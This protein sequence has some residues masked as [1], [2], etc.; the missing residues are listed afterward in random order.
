MVADN[1]GVAVGVAEEV[2][3]HAAPRTPAAWPYQVGVIPS[4]GGSFQHRAEADQLRVALDGGGTTVLSQVLT[5]TGGVGKTQLAADYARTAW[6]ESGV[7]VLVW[8]SASDTTAVISGYAQAGVEIQGA[9]PADPHSAAKAFLAWLQPK[10]QGPRCRWLVV[11]DDVT[12]PSDL[13]DWWPPASPTGRTVVTTRRKDAALA[14]DERRMIE[15]GV[16]TATESL[17][18]LTSALAVHDRREPDAQLAALAADLGHLPLALSQAAAYLVDVGVDCTAYRAL[19]SDRA[20]TLADAAPDVL[21]DGQAQTVAAAWGLSIDRAD[22]LRPVGLARPTLQLCAFLDSNGIPAAVV[23]SRSA[24]A[25]LTSYHSKAPDAHPVSADQARLAVRALYRLS[26]INHDPG[27]LHRELHVHQL[28]QHSVRDTLTSTQHDLLARTAADALTESWPEV[29]RDVDL[30]QVL[31]ANTVALTRYSGEAL[32]R[33]DLHRVLFRTGHSLGDAGQ[34]TAARDYFHH[35]SEIATAIL[36]AAH[37]DTL[38][39]R[40]GFARWQGEAGDAASAVDTL[41]E[42]LEDRLGLLGQDHPETLHT[43]HELARLR[44]EA[45]DA[46]GAVDALTPLVEHYLRV[47]GPDHLDT[48]TARHELARWQG[49]A[50][51]AVG[52]VDALTPLV[53]HYLRVLGPDH[54]DTLTARSNLARLRGEAGDVVGAVNAF[55]ELLEDRLRVLGPDHPRTLRARHELANWRIYAGDVAGAVNGFAAL[56][57]DA[58]RLLGPEHPDTLTARLNLAVCLGKAGDATGAVDALITLLGDYLR[59]IGPDHPEPLTARH[60]LARLRGEAG[61][62]AGAVT[63]FTELLQDRLRVQGPDHPHTLRAR[64]ELARWR[65][66]AGDVAGAV[67]AFTELL[68]DRL[69][70]HG[71]DHPDILSTRRELARWQA[72]ERDS[73]VTIVREVLPAEPHSPA[74]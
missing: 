2:H 67:T 70:V 61:D 65:G 62:A 57:E 48:L 72:D 60:H 74:E 32:Y 23:T 51:D 47:L 11:L 8:I 49:D 29:E 6:Q 42:L 5:G 7:D 24:L 36:G 56:V 16:F 43:R 73:D 50:G 33:P 22:A 59:V 52:A 37:P 55:A 69:R 63:T 13:S 40:H 3:Q 14:K 41:T 18:Y 30:G 45:G 9:D 12:D 17:A 64:H 10:A 19:L 21:P 66:E 44:G 38:A 46:A 15:V 71:P 39:A 58:L 31:R 25:Y 35:L 53:E 27:S 28:I 1:G 68:Q 4:R 54:L 26:L 20:R 34:V